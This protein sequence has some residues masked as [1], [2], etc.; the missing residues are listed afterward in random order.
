[1]T[2]P[3]FERLGVRAVTASALLSGLAALF[4][5][6]AYRVPLHL[7]MLVTTFRPI[8][9]HRALTLLLGFTLIYISYQLA[10]RKRTAWW[11]ALGISA[12]LVAATT[13][14]HGTIIVI[15]L[16]AINLILLVLCKDQFTARSSASSLRQGIALMVL[17]LLL[18]L[19]YGIAGFWLLD[20]RDFGQ[21]FTIDSSINRTIAE[22]TLVGNSDLQPHTR[23]AQGFLDSL[24]FIGTVSIGFGLYSLFRPLSYSLRVLPHERAEVRQ[25][26]ERYGD[27]SEGHIKLWPPDKS[28]FFTAN[29]AAAVAYRVDAGVALAVGAPV[30]SPVGR[31]QAIAAFRTMCQQNGWE[32]AFVLVPEA[33]TE[34]FG[35]D[36][37][38]LKIGEDAIVA[39]DHFT[40]KVATNKHFRNIRNRFTKQ[41][42]S[43]TESVP[44]HSPALLHELQAVSKAWQAGG[45]KQWGFLQGS[46]DSAYFTTGF[47]YTV[48]DANGVVVAFANGVSDY[49]AGQTTIDLMRHRPEAPA[50]TMDFLLLEILLAAAAAGYRT[51][52][53]GLATLSSNDKADD[54]T[55]EERIT[56]LVARLNQ[57]VMAVGGLRQFKSKFEPTWDSQYIMY[58][59]L[60]TNLVRVALAL[61]RATHVPD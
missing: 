19:F 1:M 42:F 37:R 15:G 7:G 49:V 58:R 34:L 47:L 43:F 61:S 29:R 59:G 32:P 38:R 30:G 20:K 4:A 44:P 17:S 52:N 60:P 18:A 14:Y 21:E 10:Q 28:Y 51:F 45:K 33:G 57:D 8:L 25:L 35:E 5:P 56:Q 22:F 41:A 36:W 46:F 48:R 27:C 9:F 24:D 13:L 16:A 40:D 26:L 50:N 12:Y 11:V 6:L 23:Y 2:K 54:P 39:L 55:P 3:Q 31:Q 53:L